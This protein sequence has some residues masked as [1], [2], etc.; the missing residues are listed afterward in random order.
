MLTI[1]GYLPLGLVLNALAIA[2]SKPNKAVNEL[3]VFTCGYCG[4]KK[5]KKIYT[6]TRRRKLISG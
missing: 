4:W 5:M 6:K 3:V 1:G 2:E